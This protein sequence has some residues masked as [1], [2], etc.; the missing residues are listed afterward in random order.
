MKTLS[1]DERQMRPLLSPMAVLVPNKV[2][3]YHLGE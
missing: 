3:R 1:F 2:R